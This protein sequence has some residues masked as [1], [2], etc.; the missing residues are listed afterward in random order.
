MPFKSCCL[1]VHGET[2]GDG[3]ILA[4][5]LGDAWP[6]IGAS[7][8]PAVYDVSCIV[9][10]DCKAFAAELKLSMGLGSG[11]DIKLEMG[12]SRVIFAVVMMLSRGG[13]AGNCGEYG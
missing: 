12:G 10:G 7:L 6:D 8:L 5:L 11:G 9:D 1:A 4:D 3:R 2:G 13:W